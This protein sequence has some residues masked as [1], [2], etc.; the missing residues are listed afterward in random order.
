[1]EDNNEVDET[2]MAD[3][4]EKCYKLRSDMKAAITMIN[5]LLPQMV[6]AAVS[7][8]G[9]LNS[10]VEEDV[11]EQSTA[12]GPTHP[13]PPSQSH[14]V[15]VKL[16]KLK[17][18]KFN[19]KIEEWQEF[20]D[21]FE[22]AIHQN[23]CLSKVD[24]FNYLR[25]L[26]TGQAKS[27][28]AGFSLTTANYDSADQLLKKSCGKDMLIKRTHVQEMLNVQ[29]L[30]SARDCGRL[31]AMYDKIE[32]HYHGL[33]ALGIDKA[34]YSDIVVPAILEKIPEIVRLTITHYHSHSEWSMNNV[35]TAIE[36]EIELRELYQTNHQH[37]DKGRRN[38]GQSTGNTLNAIK[39]DE[40]CAFCQGKHQH[41][42]CK[43]VTD[44]KE[45][46]QILLKYSGSFN[47]MK[48]GHRA[49]DCNHVIFFFVKIVMLNITLPCM[50]EVSPKGE[51]A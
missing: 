30:Y 20:W 2:A 17:V 26:L 11:E 12:S 10:I 29:P 35:L 47:C 50:C 22:S 34:T 9:Y 23:E 46:K 48:T 27:A 6:T 38:N 45:H 7:E 4:I 16:P 51:G 3:E 5:E 19:G 44:I 32:T 37:E 41:E 49:R 25:T 21:G 28:I 36:K 40:S 31:R 24:K 42:D 15:R 33:E 43:K 18:N 14:S 39:Q 13:Q 8:A 1:M